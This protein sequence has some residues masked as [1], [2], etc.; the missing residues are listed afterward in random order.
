MFD[1]I[2]IVVRDDVTDTVTRNVAAQLQLQ[3][4]HFNQT[5]YRS[6]TNYK[7]TV[8]VSVLDGG[9]GAPLEQWTGEGC[10]LTKADYGDMNYSENDPQTISMTVRADNWTYQDSNGNQLFAAPSSDPMGSTL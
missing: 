5:G 9:N 4:D 6:A 10:F 1:A 8:L 2:D 7:F 3:F